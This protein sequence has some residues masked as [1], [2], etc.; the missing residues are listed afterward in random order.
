MSEYQEALN[1]LN[2]IID[3]ENKVLNSLHMFYDSLDY[4]IDK[5]NDLI[6][7]GKSKQTHHK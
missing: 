2:T 6:E 1:I 5:A 7:A 4:A 3:I